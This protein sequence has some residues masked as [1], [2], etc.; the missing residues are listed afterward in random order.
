MRVEAIALTSSRSPLTINGDSE[1]LPELQWL[2]RHRA[3]QPQATS[4]QQNSID[5][6][7]PMNTFPEVPAPSLAF[8]L[9]TAFSH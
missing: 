3:P 7:V 9:F 1:E 5:R 6:W 4:L 8:P 2:T